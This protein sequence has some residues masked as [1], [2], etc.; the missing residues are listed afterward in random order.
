MQGLKRIS[1]RRRP[2]AHI[3]DRRRQLRFGIGGA[4]F[5]AVVLVATAVIYV[6]PLGQRTYTAYLDDAQSVQVGDEVRL[7]GI[8]VGSVRTLQLRP[9]RVIMRFTVDRDVFVGRE[10]TLDIRLLTMVGG[11]YVALLPNGDKPLGDTAIPADRVRLPY[12]LMQVFADAETPIRA[13]DGGTLRQNL[14]ALGDGLRTGPDTVRDILDG[15]G[16]FVELLDRQ[17]DEVSKAV[18]IADEY[19]A[20]VTAAKG[21]LHRL[22]DKVDILETVLTDKRAEVRT[23]VRTLSRVIN[24]VGALQPAWAGTFEPMARQIADAITELEHI[25]TDLGRLLDSVHHMVTKLNALVL[26]DGAVRV[27]RSEVRVPAAAIDPL[28]GTGIC[29]PVPG[30]AC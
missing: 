28:A 9:D 21:H 26:P 5:L 14:S 19:L 2:S 15:M 17:R 4:A 8:T 11:H 29:V 22:I 27:D 10:T 1:R 3:R 24:R 6:V 16:R 7:A 12:S 23:A 20:A 30:K 18:G 25:G 13:I